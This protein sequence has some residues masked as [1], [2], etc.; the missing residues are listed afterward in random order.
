MTIINGPAVLEISESNESFSASDSQAESL[1]VGHS[2]FPRRHVAQDKLGHRFDRVDIT[3][4]PDVRGVTHMP[5]G[6]L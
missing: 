1:V 2:D 5:A 6:S 3:D 4:N